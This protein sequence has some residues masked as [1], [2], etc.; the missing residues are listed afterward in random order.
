M[1][2]YLRPD[3]RAYSL[4]LAASFQRLTGRALVTDAGDTAKALWQAE[5]PVVS[6]GTEADP[7]FRYANARALELWEMDWDSFT[8][9]P[10]RLSAEAD[11]G[12][13]SDRNAL[14]AAALQ[15]GW[16]D[17]YAG[18][19]ISRSGRRF[20]ISDTVLWNVVDE[21]GTRHGQAAFIRTWTYV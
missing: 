7:V 18:I 9:L 6:H 2:P 11:A 19:R 12:I 1:L 13:Q 5:Y 14:L 8:R 17:N 10:S 21:H 4:L 16:V 20:E 15:S 3:I